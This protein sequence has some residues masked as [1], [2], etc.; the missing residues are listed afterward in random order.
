MTASVDVEFQDLGFRRT[1]ECTVVQDAGVPPAEAHPALRRMRVGGLS[2]RVTT[3]EGRV[4]ERAYDGL[5]NEYALAGA[6]G[7][8]SPEYVCVIVHGLGFMVPVNSPET[9]E[10]IPGLPLVGISRIPNRELLLIWGESDLVLY[11]PAG[12]V[13]WIEG[14]SHENLEIEDVTAD[15]ISGSSEIPS[16]GPEPYVPAA[17]I[18]FEIEIDTGRVHGGWDAAV[19]HWEDARKAH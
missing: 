10:K 6:F 19:T 18:P 12:R 16:F 7:T 13:W 5:T 9:A 11:G 1:Y 17:R 8:P 3:R 4:W 14:L 15:R 2:I